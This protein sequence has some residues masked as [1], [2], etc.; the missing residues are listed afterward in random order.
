MLPEERANALRCTATD[1]CHGMGVGLVAAITVLPLLFRFLGADEMELG[2]LFSVATAGFILGQPLGLL[3]LGRRRRTKGLLVPWIFA[4]WVPTHLALAAILY[5]L[6]PSDAR[7]CRHLM[8]GVVALVTIG[9]GMIIPIW[10][11]WQGALFDQ[12]SRGRAMGMIAGAW[13]LGNCA[14]SFAAGR[15]IEALP[16]PI[17]YCFPFLAAALL[18]TFSLVF[19][20]TVREP[21][22]ITRKRSS[23]ST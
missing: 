19:L 8:L 10:V 6:G 11:D 21:E 22:Q 15:L 1:G 14:G 7:L 17:S 2:L 13:A 3:L 20:S 12:R 4:V 18:F 5:R 16:F 9:D 23:A